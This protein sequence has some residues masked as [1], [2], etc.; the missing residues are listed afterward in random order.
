MTL[1]ETLRLGIQA[2]FNQKLRSLLTMLGVIFGVAAVIA[3]LSIG[4]GARRELLEA[5]RVLGVN[6]IIVR[7]ED[8]EGDELKEALSLNLRGLNSADV[9]ALRQILP[10]LENVVPVRRLEETVRLPMEMKA[11]LVGTTPEYARLI[12]LRL[13]EGR[14][15]KRWDG[16]GRFPVVV[17]S[18]R[19]KRKLFPLEAA[20]GKRLKVGRHWFTV[21]GVLETP[22][23][24]GKVSGIEVRDMSRDIYLPLET[25]QARFA[26]S[27]DDSPLQEIVLQ[28]QDDDMVRP[29]AAAAARVISRRHRRAKD[30]RIIV[31][32]ELLKQS[33]QTQRIFNIVMGAIA[34]ISL[35][36]GGIGIMNI[37][38]S[39]VLERTR[40]IGVRR[41][42]GA[43]R[44]DVVQQFLI[45]A[46]LLSTFGGLIGILLG[47]GMAWG[48]TL[49]AGWT[50]VVQATAVLLAFVV[51]AGVGVIFGWW[52]AKKA[53]DMNVI[54]A[55]RYE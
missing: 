49:Y 16:E 29:L 43:R 24:G 12:T 8:L 13:S 51:S 22:S 53:A 34:S 38:L 19:L 20:A 32:E 46:A 52:P 2:L 21:I 14:F 50:T 11:T 7:A 6:N 28:V 17:I 23:F 44:R 41:A 31:P 33:Q 27:T 25:M 47:A 39:N 30:F 54:N 1:G 10:G 15:L 36:V 26:L 35:L 55:L 18:E 9:A 48:I 4:A 42:V 40:E 5:I 45:E 3:M 37:M